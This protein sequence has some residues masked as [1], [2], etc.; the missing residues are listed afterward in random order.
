[1]QSQL[2]T[3]TASPSVELEITRHFQTY[4]VQVCE[5]LIDTDPDELYSILDTNLTVIE[6]FINDQNIFTFFIQKIKSEDEELT[7]QEN[8]NYSHSIQSHYNRTKET[9]ANRRCTAIHLF[10]KCNVS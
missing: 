4:F 3:P 10:F 6:Q 9:S 5:L 1:M 7:E 2:S 8:G